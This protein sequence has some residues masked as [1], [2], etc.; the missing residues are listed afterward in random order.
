MRGG[1]LRVLVAVA[2]TVIAAACGGGERRVPTQPPVVQPPVIEN[3]P[4]VVV[5]PTLTVTKIMAF[6]DSLTE[7][8]SLGQLFG[9]TLHNHGTAGVASSYPFKLKT[10]LTSTYTAQK[11]QIQV[12]NA[13]VGG[14]KVVGSQAKDRL[15]I[16]LNT[17]QP[18]VLLL[19]HGVNNVNG[20]EP[21]G[22]IVEAIEELIELAHGR[23]VHV[24]LGNLPPQRATAK[25]TGGARIGQFN[26]Q[27]PAVALEEGATFVD[28]FSNINPQTMLM[29]DGLHINETGNQKLAELFY[30]AIKARYHRE[31]VQ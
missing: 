11:D 20:P 26:S 18:Q 6:G 27:L 13:G 21:L 14:E 31:P 12:F 1:K 7:G 24:I 3:P 25:A 8:E 5:P 4:V 17:Y 15:L 30:A 19:L 10:I 23:G 22:S 16:S 9:P 29:P 2:S 28:I